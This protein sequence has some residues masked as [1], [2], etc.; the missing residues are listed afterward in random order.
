MASQPEWCV[1]RGPKKQR[2]DARL[3]AATVFGFIKS[4]I[5][6]SLLIVPTDQLRSSDFGSIKSCGLLP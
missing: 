6:S 1:M 2:P 5:A 3:P 4:V